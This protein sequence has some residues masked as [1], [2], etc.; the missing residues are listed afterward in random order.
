MNRGIFL[1]I[2]SVR[3]WLVEYTIM[4]Y[5]V[6]TKNSPIFIQLHRFLCGQSEDIIR[7][8]WAVS[9]KTLSTAEPFPIDSRIHIRFDG[10]RTPHAVSWSNGYG[11]LAGRCLCRFVSGQRSVD[12]GSRISVVPCRLRW[13]CPYKEPFFR[14]GACAR[15]RWLFFG[16]VFLFLKISR[17][18]IFAFVTD[19][20]TSTSCVYTPPVAGFI[21]AGTK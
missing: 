9:V 2:T 7:V 10:Q 8:E 19:N 4:L 13:T 21:V 18:R 15:K 6:G 20:V 1:K 3:V 5:N 14:G 16:E 12:D 11:C 17:N